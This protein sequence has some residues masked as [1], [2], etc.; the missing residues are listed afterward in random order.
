VNDIS[1]YDPATVPA[2]AREQT[3]RIA[4]VH[5]ESLPSWLEHV[6]EVET[7]KRRTAAHPPA[8]P[9]SP[10]DPCDFL[11]LLAIDAWRALAS[12]QAAPGLDPVFLGQEIRDAFGGTSPVDELCDEW[13]EAAR[14][15]GLTVEDEDG[16]ILPA[17]IQT[18]MPVLTAAF[19][20][21]LTTGHHAIA[22]G[23]YFVPRKLM[24]YC[25]STAG[26][27]GGGSR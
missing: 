14:E 20:S 27:W 12:G 23:R 9:A 26:S 5:P 1:A 7:A 4:R 10:H 15:R 25:G 22:G 18:I 19:W 16:D 17:V 3:D 13:L 21:G 2:W 8:E 11:H 6:A 24:P